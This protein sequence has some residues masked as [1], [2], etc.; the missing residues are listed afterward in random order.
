MAEPKKRWSKPEIRNLG[1]AEDVRQAI[2]SA[3]SELGPEM[4]KALERLL[5]SK[6]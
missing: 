6:A 4:R 2:A 1:R 5:N 3:S